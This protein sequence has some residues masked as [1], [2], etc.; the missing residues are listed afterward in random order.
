[1]TLSGE[2]IKVFAPLWVVGIAAVVAIQRGANYKIE[3]KGFFSHDENTVYVYH[4]R[5]S[6]KQ[7]RFLNQDLCII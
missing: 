7:G 2:L 6:N 5:H 1:M 3:S 4:L